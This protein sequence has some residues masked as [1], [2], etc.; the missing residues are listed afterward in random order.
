MSPHSLRLALEELYHDYAACLDDGELERWPEFFTETCIYKVVPREN[1]ERGLPLAVLSCES[2]AGLQDRVTAVRETAV[3]GPRALRHIVS[4]VRV[5]EQHGE[6][7]QSTASYAV[8]ETLPGEETR[9][10]NV[11]RYLDVVVRDGV[12]L[13]FAERICVFDSVLVPGSLVYPI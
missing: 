12:A 9:V 2:R 8:F 13:R 11:G 1:H 4:G 6:R 5:L 3:F 7:I 10:F